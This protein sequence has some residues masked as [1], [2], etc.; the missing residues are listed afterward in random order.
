MLVVVGVG[1]VTLSCV[2]LAW[3]VRPQRS[4]EEE[5][6][7]M[8]SVCETILEDGENTPGEYASCEADVA[9]KRAISH[10]Q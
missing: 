2:A 4:T 5:V 1:A 9:H 10:N 8:E 7:E 6:S 3:Y